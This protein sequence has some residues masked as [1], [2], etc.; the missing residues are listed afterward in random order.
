MIIQQD[1]VY[2]KSHIIFFYYFYF[3]LLFFIYILFLWT[4]VIRNQK[5][6]FWAR[7]VYHQ[8]DDRNLFFSSSYGYQ[9]QW[10]QGN[11][12]LVI[13]VQWQFRNG[14]Y[15]CSNCALKFVAN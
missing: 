12:T 1:S 11:E 10:L 6:D 2:G 3:L 5:L 9:L 14:Y 13:L 4:I 7:D 15:I 8:H